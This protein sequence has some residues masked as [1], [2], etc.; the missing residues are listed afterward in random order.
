[1]LTPLR[2][3]QE[4]SVSIEPIGSVDSNTTPLIEIMQAF[5]IAASQRHPSAQQSN[6]IGYLTAGDREFLTALYGSAVLAV[7]STS[8][9]RFG[10]PQ[11]LLDVIADRK[12]GNLPIGTELTSS[13][14]QAR[15]DA[16]VD[17]N[18]TLTNPLTEQNLHDAQIY[19]NDRVQGA[20]IDLKA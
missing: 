12:N 16:H 15:F 5:Q 11:F 17:L 13:Y 7:P 20:A 18:G 10:T 1:M 6:G 9:E 3:G 8:A 4:L 2:A 14:V 19:F